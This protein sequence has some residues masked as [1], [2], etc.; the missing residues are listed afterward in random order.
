MLVDFGMRMLSGTPPSISV[1]H[2]DAIEAADAG[3]WTSVS[4]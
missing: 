4:V 3:V 1:R 2:H